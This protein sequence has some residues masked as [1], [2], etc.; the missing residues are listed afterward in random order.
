MEELMTSVKHEMDQE[1]GVQRASLA[2]AHTLA[3]KAC[4]CLA[5]IAATHEETL[6]QFGGRACSEDGPNSPVGIE[7]DDECRAVAIVRQSNF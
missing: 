1:A 7:F 4:A 3:M 6:P 2:A 5:Q